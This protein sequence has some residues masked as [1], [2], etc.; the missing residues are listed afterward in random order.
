LGLE[1]E[2]VYFYVAGWCEQDQ[3]HYQQRQPAAREL[4]RQALCARIMQLF[5]SLSFSAAFI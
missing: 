2:S 4:L 1:V 3:A 5:F